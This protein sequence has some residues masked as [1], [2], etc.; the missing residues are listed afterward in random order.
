MTRDDIMP[1]DLR[2]QV[3]PLLFAAE[4][5]VEADRRARVEALCTRHLGD[6]AGEV[7]AVLFAE[8]HPIRRKS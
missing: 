6:D 4:A 1:R 5:A 8:P 2:W 7:L 3:A